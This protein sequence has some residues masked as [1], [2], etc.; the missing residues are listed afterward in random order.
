MIL[1]AKHHFLIYLFFKRY[2][3]WIIKKNFSQVIT[4]GI[5]QERNLP[6]LIISNHISWWDG[7][8]AMNLN[9]KLFNRKFYFMMLEEQLRKYWFF[10]YTGG[11]SIHKKS[12]SVVESINYTS[13]LLNN[14]KNIVLI[15]PQGKIQSM[16]KQWF[17]FESGIE[18]ILKKIDRNKIQIIFLINMI[19]YFSKP[20]PSL[21]QYIVEYKSESTT[22]FDIEKY[23]NLFYQKSI[24]HQIKAEV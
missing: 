12:R 7:F 10:N 21:Y 8:W 11:Y 23:F 16:H 22:C 6:V 13:D 3:Q 14:P 5:I 19:D 18:K 2:S 15:F 9:L 4:N 17:E 1:K 20:K 24:E